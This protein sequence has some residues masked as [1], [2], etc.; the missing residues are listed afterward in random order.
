MW[1]FYLYIFFKVNVFFV[2]FLLWTHWLIH[3]FISYL[4]IQNKRRLHSL[5][6]LTSRP[7]RSQSASSSEWPAQPSPG[8]CS[9]SQASRSLSSRRADR[10]RAAPRGVLGSS[11][12]QR[13]IWPKKTKRDDFLRRLLLEGIFWKLHLALSNLPPR[14]PPYSIGEHSSAVGDKEQTEI[15]ISITKRLQI[16]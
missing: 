12:F 13:C 16:T 1:Y 14:T 11:G 4:N 2:R 9:S 6:D 15:E 8:I 5:W 10:G 3:Y 7:R